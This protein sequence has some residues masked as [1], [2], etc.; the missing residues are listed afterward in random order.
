MTYDELMELIQSI[1]GTLGID[2][3]ES[4]EEDLDLTIRKL[5]VDREKIEQKRNRG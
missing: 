1:K 3:I 4:I 5:K 2:I